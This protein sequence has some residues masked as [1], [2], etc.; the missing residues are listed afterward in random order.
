MRV[1]VILLYLG[2]YSTF[3]LICFK[4][5][6]SKTSPQ[7][8]PFLTMTFLPNRDF[9]RIPALSNSILP[10]KANSIRIHPRKPLEM[11]SFQNDVYLFKVW[12]KPLGYY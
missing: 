4:A 1:F 5:S 10:L 8:S 6:S 11:Q 9:L 7:G 3:T 12:E 2:R